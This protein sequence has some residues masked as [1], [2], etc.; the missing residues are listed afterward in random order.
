MDPCESEN[1]GVP[2][3]ILRRVA[4]LAVE[5]PFK[6]ARD[7]ISALGHQTLSATLALPDGEQRVAAFLLKVEGIVGTNGQAHG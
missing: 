4:A 7:K 2:P 5:D 1:Y 6:Y 3:H